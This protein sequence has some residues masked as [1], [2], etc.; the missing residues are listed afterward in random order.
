[1]TGNGNNSGENGTNGTNGSNFTV[2]GNFNLSITKV[3]NVTSAKIGD[4]VK[5]T[6]TVVNHGPDVAPNVTVS[7]HPGSSLVYNATGVVSQGYYDSVAGLWYVGDLANGSSETLELVFLVNG[8]ADVTNVVN[9]SSSGNNSGENGTNGTNGSN[10]TV[11]SFANISIVK[12]VNVS[13]EVLNG[14]L[15]KYTIVVTNHGPDNATGVNVT[16]K[17]D[18]RLIYIS[19]VA[20]Q[21]AYDGFSGLWIIGDLDNGATV[22][23]DIIVRL[24]GTGNLNNLA[25]VTID[26]NNTGDVNSTGNGTDTN[27]TVLPAVNISI[28]KTANVSGDIAN[29]A[30]IKYTIVVVNYGPDN[31]TGVNVTDVLNNHLIYINSVATQ[32][33]YDYKTGKWVIGNIAVGKTVKLDIFVRI[34]GTGNIVNFATLT[35]DQNN[36]HNINGSGTDSVNFTSKYPTKLVL[37]TPKVYGQYVQFKA[38]LT[39]SGKNLSG[40]IVKFYVNGKYIGQSKTNSKGLAT[41]NSKLNVYGKLKVSAVFN[42]DKNYLSS[43]KTITFAHPKSGSKIVYKDS[44]VRKGRY[45]LATYVLINVGSSSWSHYFKEFTKK[46][47]KIFKV[48]VSKFKVSY[49]P[50]TRSLKWNIRGLKPRNMAKMYILYDYKY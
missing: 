7:E 27:I 14:A 16:D 31:A 37:S 41:L 50:E 48:K 25:N 46:Y 23:L 5:Y 1:V 42:T 49:N 34:N 29:G 4:L 9:V 15:I 10:F 13:G 44:I 35:V 32:G 21:G 22:S 19:S 26:Q 8:S 40:K 47:H 39:Q 24:N 33:N 28:T 38:T 12:T 43:N 36:T 45:Y 6:I 2:G 30:L 3:V 18:S 20:S 17:L 11:I